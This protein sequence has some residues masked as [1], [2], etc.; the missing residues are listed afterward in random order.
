MAV[1]RGFVRV[2]ALAVVVAL[3]GLGLS[4][5]AAA[6]KKGSAAWCAKHPKQAAHLAA[7]SASSGSGS[8]TGGTG[9]VITVQVDPNPLPEV[10]QSEV[11][12]VIQVEASP[13]FAGDPVLVSSSQLAAS[14]FTVS[15]IGT[16]NVGTTSVVAFLDDDGNATVTAEGLGC[17]PGPDVFEADLTVSPFL[18]ATTTVD[19]TPPHVLTPGVFANPTTSGSVTTG[20]VET[21]DTPPADSDIINVFYVVT[22]PVYAEQTVE[23]DSAQ[24][25]SRCAA[26]WEWLP[27][28]LAAGGS[29]ANGVGLNPAPATAILDDDGNAVFTFFGGECSAGPS[30][31][32]A[33]VES[34]LHP[35]Y[36]TTFTIVA[37]VPTV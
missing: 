1:R 16:V 7:C 9:A 14:C 27:G 36:L 10:G 23:I 25:D 20:Q 35:T 28:N 18:T 8:G 37:P 21:G 30:D 11:Y 34:G 22:N 12:A 33:D 13:S 24:L 6:A 29:I 3:A 4:G 19:V 26:G 32:V 15:Y 2:V 31:V 17:A 5:V